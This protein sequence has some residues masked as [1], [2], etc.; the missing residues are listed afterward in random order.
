LSLKR[1]AGKGLL[2]DDVVWP[3]EMTECSNNPGVRYQEWTFS[4]E[5]DGK[6]RI[7]NLPKEVSYLKSKCIGVGKIGVSQSGLP[8]LGIGGFVCNGTDNIQL[9]ESKNKKFRYE[10]SRRSSFCLSDKEKDGLKPRQ[11]SKDIANSEIWEQKLIA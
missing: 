2:K 9:F 11:C 10:T 6:I 1:P 8:M 5:I 3:A 7:I 4:G